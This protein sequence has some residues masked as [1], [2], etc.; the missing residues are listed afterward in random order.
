MNCLSMRA[1]IEAPLTPAVPAPTNPELPDPAVPTA[2]VVPHAGLV[3]A[4]EMVGTAGSELGATAPVMGDTA[5]G[6]AAA[7]LTPGLLSSVESIG[8]PVR[9]KPPGVV[10]DVDVGVDDEA[11]LLA[12]E[13]HIPDMP[14]V[15]SI[16]E[17]VDMAD[18]PDI[19]VD[20]VVP[21][22]VDVPDDIDVDVP[23]VAVAP[24][25]AAVAGVAVPAAVPP[26]S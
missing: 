18:V 23:A 7:E 11:M 1:E 16:P 12:P 26:P 2:A 21:G 8:I 3:A 15:S 19:P 5:V 4:G 24:D 13:P 9:A 10:G 25:V 20:A 14:E 17:D 22:A 6:I